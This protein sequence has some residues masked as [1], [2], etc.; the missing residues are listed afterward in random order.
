MRRFSLAILLVATNASADPVGSQLQACAAIADDTE[1]LHCYDTLSQ[2]LQQQVE[3]QRE[4]NFGREQQ[5]VA[6]ESPKSINAHIATVQ[7]VAYGKLLIT[8]DNGQV[9]RQ[10]DS[11]RVSWKPGDAMRVDRALFGSFLMREV[12]AGRS[13]R[14]KRVR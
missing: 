2:T 4:Q 7:K 3:Q 10:T 1:R 12:D 5:Q 13:V 6:E 14:V 11:T 9:W 8:L